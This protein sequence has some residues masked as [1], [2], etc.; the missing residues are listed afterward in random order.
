MWDHIA[1]NTLRTPSLL[2][3]HVALK[4][5]VAVYI[6]IGTKETSFV[7]S[8]DDFVESIFQ[9][10]VMR[11]GSCNKVLLGCVGWV[12]HCWD[13]TGQCAAI[14]NGTAAGGRQLGLW[15][16]LLVLLK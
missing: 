16:L 3:V 15:L 4:S 14:G 13:I 2:I 7:F 6:V 5:C 11:I 9:F 1:W 8:I 10:T 12:A